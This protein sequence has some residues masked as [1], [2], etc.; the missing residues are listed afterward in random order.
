[1]KKV[2]RAVVVGGCCVALASCSTASLTN[3]E[4]FITKV[5]GVIT[6][7]QDYVAQSCGI[8]PEAAGIVAIYNQLAGQ[9][10]SVIG[11]A[12]CVALQAATPVPAPAS[13]K[14]R[15]LARARLGVA[16]PVRVC[17]GKVCGWK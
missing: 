12:V 2:L 9:S 4:N 16:N 3:T 5:G 17:A 11:N 15:S 8:I 1:M 6:Q 7:I 14:F 10:I 13:S